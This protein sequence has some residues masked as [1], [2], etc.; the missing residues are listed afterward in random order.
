MS[1][2][3]KFILELSQKV[4]GEVISGALASGKVIDPKNVADLAIKTA[5]ELFDQLNENGH[6]KWWRTN[7]REPSSKIQAP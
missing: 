3:S 6:L 4:L 7:G 2:R 1:E 5:A